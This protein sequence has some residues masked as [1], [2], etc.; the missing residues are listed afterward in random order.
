MATLPEF[1]HERWYTLGG[2]HFIAVC[3]AL[4]IALLGWENF[5]KQIFGTEIQMREKVS[6]MRL[7]MADTVEGKF[8]KILGEFILVLFFKLNRLGWGIT[9]CLV[10]L[11]SLTGLFMLWA[12]MTCPF[13]FFLLLLPSACRISL[14][15]AAVGGTVLWVWIVEMMMRKRSELAAFL[16]NQDPPD[17]QPPQP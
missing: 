4:N 7:T 9:Y 14:R 17:G 11:A 16:D 5:R 1:F 15:W 13:D 2:E 6:S 12:K 10:V 8:V 3:T